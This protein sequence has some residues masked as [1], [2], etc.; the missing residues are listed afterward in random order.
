MIGV[1]YHQP[2][3]GKYLTS[4]YNNAWYSIKGPDDDVVISTR[5][6]LARNLVNYPFPSRFS[7]SDGQT[8]KTLVFD[9]FAHI[10]HSEK[11]QS[12][13]VVKLDE[14]G[15]KILI[16]RGA[17]PYEYLS[18]PVSGIIVRSDGQLMCNVNVEDH[19]HFAAFASGFDVLSVYNTAKSIDDEV[20]TKVQVAAALD[21]GYLTENMHN[22]GSAAK[23]SVFVHLP[24]LAVFNTQDS[25]LTNILL[26]LEKNNFSVQSVFGLYL[27][28]ENSF[29][30]ALGNCYQISTTDTFTGTLDD[31]MAYFSNAIQ[32]VIEAERLYREKLLEKKP[33]LLRDAVY[34]ALATVKY[35]RF[36][37]A[38][39]G[40]N[41]LFTL[42]W[43]EDAQILTKSNTFALPSLLY[44][45]Q[46]GHIAF[47]NKTERFKFEKD[48]IEPEI[49][50]QRLRSLIMQQAVEN[51]Q[52]YS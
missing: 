38:R 46:D 50:V 25:E 47:V 45:I 49:Q 41:I 11:Y 5:L 20:Q 14:I 10:E 15:Q 3:K 21:F 23:F 42:K 43:G 27:D 13:T 28:S 48:V 17:L 44:R 6:R 12:L 39:E 29:S 24:S 7:H 30:Q 52:I 51:I 8:V 35:S 19:I 32:N 37:T 22:L 4:D 9:A 1:Q 18:N 26:E 34:K 31:H 16:E 36:L 33:T 40:I 2:M